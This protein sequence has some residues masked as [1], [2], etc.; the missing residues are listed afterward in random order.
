MMIESLNILYYFAALFTTNNCKEK[1]FVLVRIIIIIIISGFTA[2]RHDYLAVNFCTP[3]FF[4]RDGGRAR[5]K[6]H[7]EGTPGESIEGPL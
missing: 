5:T 3:A 4:G 7:K 6:L 2:A 1:N